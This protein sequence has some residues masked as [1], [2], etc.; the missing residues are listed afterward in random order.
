MK[1]DLFRGIMQWEFNPPKSAP[2]KKP[3]KLPVFYRDNTSITVIYTASTKKIRGLL[4]DPLMHP[5]ELRPGR[6]LIAFTAFE[7]RD[8]DIDPYNEFSIAPLISYGKK[9]IPGLALVPQMMTGNAEA[10]V[11][12]LPVTTEIARYGGVELYNYPKFLAS[13]SFTRDARAIRCELGEKKS[14]ILS[15]TGPVLPV[16]PGRTTRYRTYPVKDGVTLC[17]NVVTLHHEFAQTRDTRGVTLELGKDHPAARDLAGLGL[18]RKA[19]LYMY[20]PRNESILF[21]PRNLI[22]D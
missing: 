12:H 22:D 16:S 19:L 14:K 13:I 11:W 7:Y 6:A 1:G 18:G 15:L 20:S 8:T 10:Y 4:P 2:T 21:A 3:F 5:A 9:K 17:G